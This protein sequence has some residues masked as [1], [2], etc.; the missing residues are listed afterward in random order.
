MKKWHIGCSGFYYKDWRG[1][2]YPEGLAQKNWFE[3][4]CSHFNTI[5]LNVTFYRFP[6]LSF[7]EGWYRK[8]PK[9]FT[10][11]VKAPRAITHYKKFTDTERLIGDF[12]EVIHTGLKEKL[13]CV[14]FQLPPKYDYSE[15]KLEKIINSLDTSFQNVLEFRHQS[16]WQE[17][18]YEE[19]SGHNITFCGMSHPSLPDTVVKNTPVLYYRMHG[20][21]EL[22]RSL[23][24]P[25]ELKKLSDDIKRSRKV[26]EAYIYFN[27]DIDAAAINNAN[28]IIEFVKH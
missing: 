12:Y 21:S 14:L 3:Y 28:Q 11:S 18:V 2:F 27:N 7:A 9:D 5:E 13:G 24:S 16:W 25:A 23:Y 15:E 17:K 4:Y 1:K 6:K 19:L 10:F 26:K 8:S 20:K 22:Y